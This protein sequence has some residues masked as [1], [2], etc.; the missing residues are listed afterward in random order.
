MAD[1]LAG[2]EESTQALGESGNPVGRGMV[3][4]QLQPSVE[5]DSKLA[6]QKT[7]SLGRCACG[8][9]AQMFSVWL[10]WQ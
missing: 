8:M 6:L 1:R 2:V 5:C 9:Q 7:G 10:A 4:G 3:A